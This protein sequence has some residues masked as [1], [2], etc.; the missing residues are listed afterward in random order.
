MNGA[1]GVHP[2]GTMG[3]PGDAETSLAPIPTW[4]RGQD[5]TKRTRPESGGEHAL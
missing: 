1:S 5:M 3:G 2:F 4:I